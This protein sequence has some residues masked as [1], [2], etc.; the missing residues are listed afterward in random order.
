MKN[1]K[2]IVAGLRGAAKGFQRSSRANYADL[3]LAHQGSIDLDPFY[4]DWALT[5][6]ELQRASSRKARAA[7][8]RLM[9]VE[10]TL[11]K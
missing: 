7:L 8:F 6:Q 3:A 9:R 1:P 10:R 2:R 4:Y 5:F 11:R